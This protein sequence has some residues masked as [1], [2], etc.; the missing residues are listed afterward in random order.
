MDLLVRP[1]TP[2]ILIDWKSDSLGGLT[3]RILL[4]RTESCFSADDLVFV[5]END[6][7]QSLNNAPQ[8]SCQYFYLPPLPGCLFCSPLPPPPR[9]TNP[10]SSTPGRQMGTS[11]QAS[12][13]A[14]GLMNER[15]FR[16]TG[17]RGKF[18]YYPIPV[19]LSPTRNFQ[20]LY[21]LAFFQEA[22][23]Q[24]PVADRYFAFTN[25]RRVLVIR[26]ALTTPNSG[27]TDR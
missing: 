14:P 2:T 19:A 25:N 27:R 7:D 26:S 17:E 8:N 15:F 22:G 9:T 3:L 5:L 4:K 23:V 13:A 20:R 21:W 1:W 18:G 24:F 12:V 6:P 11:L 16:T 10:E